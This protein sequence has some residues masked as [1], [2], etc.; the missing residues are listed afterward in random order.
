MSVSEGRFGCFSALCS[1]WMVMDFSVLP[2][3]QMEWTSLI[4]DLSRTDD[5]VERHFLELKSDVDLTGSAGRAKVVKFILGAANRDPDTAARY[6]QGHALMVLGVAPGAVT[7]IAPFEAMDLA[8]FVARYTGTPGP[9]WDFQRVPARE[10][11]DV[12][13]ILVDPPTGSVWTCLS[14]GPE[15]LTDGAIFVRADGETRFAKGAEIRAMV[16][17]GR[18]HTV[19]AELDVAVVGRAVRHPHGYE[20]VLVDYIEAHRERLGE[21][22]ARVRSRP[23]TRLAGFD[24]L[25]AQFSIGDRRKPEE[26]LA[27]V[28]SW[29]EEVRRAWPEVLDHLAGY[30][31]RGVHLRIR[32]SS[33]A[34]LENV[35]VQVHIEG[36]VRA[37]DPVEDDG[38]DLSSRLPALPVRWG[39]TTLLSSAFALNNYPVPDVLRPAAMGMGVLYHNGGSTTLTMTLDA[40]RPRSV[41]DTDP[42]D[43]AL[44][45]DGPDITELRGTWRITARGHHRVYEGELAVPV[46]QLGDVDEPIRS[47]LMPDDADEAD[48]AEDED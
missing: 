23:G 17:R 34:F 38:L 6:F 27:E 39:A 26:F 32:N 33:D 7:G 46:K 22:S 5:R 24:T 12:I 2:R 1:G 42:G 41:H 29:Q 20:Q 3:G 8:R 28:E 10:G 43:F 9:R 11:R 25:G 31:G 13:V 19:P 35:E 48:T 44:V 40:L 37:V 16:D 15:K 21:A 14:D 45:V 30:A 18:A 36:E 4:D 47:A